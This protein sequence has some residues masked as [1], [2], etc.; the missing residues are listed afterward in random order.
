MGRPCRCRFSQWLAAVQSSLCPRR[1]AYSAAS[2][3]ADVM[4][5][6]H[7]LPT[8]AQVLH[9]GCSAR[10]CE[11]DTVVRRA[12]LCVMFMCRGSQAA[13]R[14][15]PADRGML[16][17]W[18]HAWSMST[19]C[20]VERNVTCQGRARSRR[21]GAA[22]RATEPARGLPHRQLD[23]GW[24]VAHRTPC[25][26]AARGTPAP[27]CWPNARRCLRNQVLS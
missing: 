21:C 24:T 16:A 3:V 25:Q 20:W 6:P 1:I 22:H 26:S 13:V 17:S 27:P 7:V 14:A 5:G 12:A 23:S 18:H 2:M 4:S 10:L 9:T 15:V 8:C 19:W 11:H